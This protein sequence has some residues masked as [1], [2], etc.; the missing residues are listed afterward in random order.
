MSDISTSK[1]EIVST[2]PYACNNWV[3]KLLWLDC[4]NGIELPGIHGKMGSNRGLLKMIGGY[5]VVMQ[6]G[7]VG[8]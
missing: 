1:F 5:K 2:H 4:L 7:T 6:V 8:S 3:S